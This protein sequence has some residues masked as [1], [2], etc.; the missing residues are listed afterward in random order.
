[1]IVEPYCSFQAQTRSVNASRPSSS[2]DAALRGEL[3]LDH[4]L[5]RDPGVVGAQDPER[6]PP[7]HPV[8]AD[9]RILD[10]P[11]EGMPHVEGAGD[12]GR[13]DRD[14][15]VLLRRCPPRAGGTSRPPSSARRRAAL[16][17]RDPSGWSPRASFGAPRPR[18]DVK[19]RPRRDGTR[20]RDA[21]PGR[22]TRARPGS[23]RPGRRA[24]APRRSPPRHPPRK[25][26]RRGRR[27]ATGM[28]TPADSHQSSP[29]P[30]ANTIPCWG[31]G[32]SMPCGTTRPDRR[33]RSW[34][35]SLTTTWS[36]RGRS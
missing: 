28:S 10:G 4:R 17:R 13:R 20:S 24:G 6:V 29:G 7:A 23:R 25:G 30:T 15:V 18:G 22:A 8:D 31:G 16:P 33:M 3:L 2:R 26:R 1:M 14:R 11:V 36:N 32:S 5:R 27:A 19:S 21:A 34:S 35:S 9:Q 12:V